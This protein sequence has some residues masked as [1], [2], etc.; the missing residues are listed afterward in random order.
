MF[1]SNIDSKPIL[2][3][4]GVLTLFDGW[5][6]FD[7]PQMT[8]SGLEQLALMLNLMK[9]EADALSNDGNGGS[10]VVIAGFFLNDWIGDVMTLYNAAINV[11]NSVKNQKG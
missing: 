10:R 5:V 1:D 3:T 11:V 9:R 2:K 4:T 8:V 7:L 6:Q